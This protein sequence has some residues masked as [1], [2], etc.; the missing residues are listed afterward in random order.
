MAFSGLFDAVDDAVAK[1][2]VCPH[3]E[4]AILNTIDCIE[5]ENAVCASAGYAPNFAMY[6]NGERTD[7]EMSAVWWVGAFFVLDFQLDIHYM[8]QID[9]DQVLLEYVETVTTNQGDVFLQHET[10]YVTLNSACQIEVWDQYGDDAE[11]QAVADAV[12]ELVPSSV[13]PI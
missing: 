1:V 4:E 11:Q 13:D 8:E 12:A 7:V 9:D 3:P 6:H 5:W 10:A 2:W